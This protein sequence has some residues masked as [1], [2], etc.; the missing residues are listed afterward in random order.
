MR[1]EVVS[2]HVRS[3]MENH[4]TDV[5]SSDQHTVNHGL[6]ENSITRLQCKISPITASR[7]SAGA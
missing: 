6:A 5:L 4:L 1:E 7:W 2:S 3:L